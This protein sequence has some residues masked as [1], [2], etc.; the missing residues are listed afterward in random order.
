MPIIKAQEPNTEKPFHYVGHRGASYLAPENTLASIKLAWELG[1]DGAE[2]DVMLTSDQ[3]VVLFHDNNTKTL[4]GENFTIK[5]ATW[6]ELKQLVVIPR[7]T[8]YP[9]Y[10][11]E[12]IPLLEDVLASIPEDRMLV[13]EIKTG[14]EILP[15]LQEVIAQH[16]KRGKI[17]FIAFDFETIKQTKALYPE[18]PCYYLSSF[19]P[20]FNKHFDAIVESQLDGVDL[21]HTIIDRELVEK[22]NASGLDVWCWTVN[23]PE[24]ALQMRE[25]GVTAVTTD[26]PAWLKNSL[27]SG[28]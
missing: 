2:C 22:C 9:E 10:N 15:F 18:I 4:T 12:T 16:L 20:D 6:E 24:I 5:E 23:D 8:N 21:R 13:I 1:A 14:S 25:A 26:R 7:E 17:S 27:S 3:K 19:K 28:N 11:H